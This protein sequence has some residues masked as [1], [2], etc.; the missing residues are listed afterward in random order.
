M[1]ELTDFKRGQIVGAR[2]VGASVDKVVEVFSVSRGTVSKTYSAY[3]KSGKTFSS[4]SQRGPKL[5]LSDRD[6]RSLRRIV[7]KHKKTT[8]AK[9]TAEMN[10]MLTNPVST[11]TKRRELH[12][13]GISG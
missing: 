8:A 6:R 11:K 5:V 7:T 4:K 3:L 2:L 9:V 13:Q 10:V 1:S 12:K